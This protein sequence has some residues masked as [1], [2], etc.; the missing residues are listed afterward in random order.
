MQ[1]WWVL[2]T[3]NF[4]MVAYIKSRL[5]LVCIFIIQNLYYY[6]DLFFPFMISDFLK[7][8]INH[9]CWSKFMSPSSTSSNYFFSSSLLV[10]FKSCKSHTRLHPFSPLLCKI[11]NQSQFKMFPPS[12]I[13]FLWLPGERGHYFWLTVIWLWNGLYPS[14]AYQAAG[15]H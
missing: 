7:I 6:N 9:P 15:Y 1:I 8:L 2:L 14:Q 3:P 11:T 10:K 13:H 5:Y 4:L 12:T